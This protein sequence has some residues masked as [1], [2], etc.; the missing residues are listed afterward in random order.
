MLL[1]RLLTAWRS[2]LF[3]VLMPLSVL[4]FLANRCFKMVKAGITSAAV[5]VAELIFLISSLTPAP[6]LFFPVNPLRW[7]TV[8]PVSCGRHNKHKEVASLSEG[9]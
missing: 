2:V 3:I 6:P 9:S 7:L 8:L 5:E 4:F 1:N